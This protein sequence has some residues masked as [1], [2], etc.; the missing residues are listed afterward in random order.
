[1]SVALA[2]KNLKKSYGPLQ[3]VHGISFEAHAGEIFGLLGPNGAGKTTTLEC[4]IGLRPPDAGSVTVCDLD[5]LRH[6]RQ[7]KQRIAVALQATAF[8]DNISPREALRRF[9][10]F[11]KR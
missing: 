7:A 9:P 2:V 4:I 3:A 11:F 8:S 1:M 10:I 6:P 5:A